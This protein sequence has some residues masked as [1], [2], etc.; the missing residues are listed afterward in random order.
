MIAPMIALILHLCPRANRSITPRKRGSQLQDRRGV[1]CAV[2]LVAVLAGCSE[3]KPGSVPVAA[4]SAPVAS[5]SPSTPSASTPAAAAAE[6]TMAIAGD[7]HFTG[8]TAPL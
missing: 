4:S 7:V 6:F 5:A 3:G 2:V 8:R 1:F